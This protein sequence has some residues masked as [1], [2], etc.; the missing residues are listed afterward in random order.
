MITV[1]KLKDER[2][3]YLDGYYKITGSWAIKS[4]KGW[5]AFKSNPHTPYTPAG[6]KKVLLE[7]IEDQNF[8]NSDDIIFIK[9]M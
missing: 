7:L 1:T 2:F 5:L 8:L 6:G 3:K 9:E 4:E